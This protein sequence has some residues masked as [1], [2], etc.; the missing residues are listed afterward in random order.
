MI[1][2]EFSKLLKKSKTK[3]YVSL[4]AKWLKK[5]IS[6]PAKNNIDKIIQKEC[7][8]A[9]NNKGDFLIIPKSETGRNLTQSLYNYIE[10]VENVDVSRFLHEH[11]KNNKNCQ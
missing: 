9:K 10:S 2:N 11:K 6:R 8:F 7:W 4:A 3:K 1:L 5:K